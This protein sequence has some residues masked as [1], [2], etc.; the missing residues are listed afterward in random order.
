[1]ADLTPVSPS[2]AANS[3]SFASAAAGG[4]E[5]P[6]TGK[7]LVVIK[8]GGGSGITLTVTTTLTVDGEPV[9]DKEITVGAGET[10][11]LGPW[12]GNIYSD[13]DGKVSLGYSDNTSVEVAVIKP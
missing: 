9:D 10:H 11:L 12:P 4:D 1:M 6:N 8:N 13:N 5:F 7:E 3:F 2:R